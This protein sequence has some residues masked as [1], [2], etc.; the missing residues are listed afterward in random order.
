MYYFLRSS[1][2]GVSDFYSAKKL[3][4][5]L[6]YICNTNAGPSKLRGSG[7]CDLPP[8]FVRSVNPILTRGADSARHIT[9]CPPDFQIYLRPCCALLSSQY[10]SS[11][12]HFSGAIRCLLLSHI[13]DVIIFKPTPSN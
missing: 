10:S 3:L 6:G 5:P 2:R 7:G 9:T 12:D 4:T 1:Y 11:N 8:D 13:F